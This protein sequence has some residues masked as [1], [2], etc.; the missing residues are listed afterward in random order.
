MGYVWLKEIKLGES[1]GATG[2]GVKVTIVLVMNIKYMYIL[3]I[4]YLFALYCGY[5]R[6]TTG[7]MEWGEEKWQ[8]K[9]PR[10]CRENFG[11]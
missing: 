5:S 10:I 4:Q 3:S 2:K 8:E 11:F 1:S 6:S 9:L 7:E